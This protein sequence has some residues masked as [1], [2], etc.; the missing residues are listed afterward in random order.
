M[1]LGHIRLGR[2][3]KTRKWR[4]VFEVLEMG[5]ADPA[6][7]AVSVA[8]AAERDFAD[9]HA[10]PGVVGDGLWVISLLGDFSRS[11]EARDALMHLGMQESSFSSPSRLISSLPTRAQLGEATAAGAVFDQMADLSLKAA[12]GRHF[13]GGMLPLFGSSTDEVHDR[14]QE[15]GSSPTYAQVARDFLG[16]FMSRVV[17]YA[18]DR[19]ASNFLGSSDAWS[20]AGDLLALGDRLDTYC[21]DSSRIVQDFA[22]GWHSKAKYHTAEGVTREASRRFAA[23]ALTKL[24]MELEGCKDD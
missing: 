14:C 9:L 23:H 19:E 11:A 4:S 13:S 21:R 6:A 5:N 1:H 8:V 12:I 24:R 3:P 22:D 15:L 16:E 20:T 17:R 2:L 10:T 7:V 18:V